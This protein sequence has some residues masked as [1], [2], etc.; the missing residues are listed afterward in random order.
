M[1]VGNRRNRRSWLMLRT[2]LPVFLGAMLLAVAACAP[3][4]PP[5]PPPP[6]IPSQV[7]S[8][9]G[10]KFSVYGLRLPGTSQE[11]KM[12]KNG[13]LIWLP[14]SIVEFVRFSGPDV[15]NYRQAEIV[16]TSGERLGGEVF[17]GQLIQ[18]TTDVGY[19]NMSLKDVRNLSMG[20]E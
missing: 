2:P 19:W 8:E 6:K 17:V 11:F 5:P 4:P 12:R 3:P 15:D 1:P 7:I 9:E 10:M 14:L 18:G 13:A 16:L 20:E